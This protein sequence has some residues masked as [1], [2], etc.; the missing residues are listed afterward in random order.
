MYLSY[1]GYRA[2]RGTLTA[3][4][5]CRRYMGCRIFEYRPFVTTNPISVTLSLVI[6][7]RIKTSSPAAYTPAP[8]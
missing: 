3:I 4:R 7:A 8:T 1:S 5:T 6:S 2:K